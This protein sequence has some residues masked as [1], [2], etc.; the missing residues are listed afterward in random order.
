M[1]TT[2]TKRDN[3]KRDNRQP[4]SSRRQL[5]FGMVVGA[6]V[7]GATILAPRSAA[8]AKLSQSDTGYQNH[9]N[10]AQRCDTCANWQAPGSCKLVN[11]TISPSGWCTLF[12]ARK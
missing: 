8:A 6:G 9:P 7:A 10:G 5:I 2:P 1:L 3:V 4:A 11:G 12:A